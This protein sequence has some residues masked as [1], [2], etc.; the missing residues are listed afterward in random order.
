M[1]KAEKVVVG[2]Y[3]QQQQSLASDPSHSAWV[4]ANAGSGKT[5]VLARRVVRL[6]FSGCD[7]SRI[8]CLTFT[9]A[10]AGEMSNRVFAILGE[11]AVWP[12]EQ[13]I[14]EL[15]E[16]QGK[17]PTRLQVARARTLF[18]RALETPGGLK[19][20][21]VHAFCEALLHQFP[22]EANIPGN[23]SVMEDA[24]QKTLVEQARRAVI[25]DAQTQNETPL[26]TAFRR[27]LEFGTDH[28]FEK[29][30]TQI[31]ARRDELAGWLKEIGGPHKA[32]L[33][34]KRNFGF[35]G[36]ETAELLILSALKNCRLSQHELSVLH[37]AGKDKKEKSW[38]RRLSQRIGSFLE[39]DNA[40]RK[41]EALCFIFLSEKSEPRKYSA[42]ATGGL[43]DLISDFEARLEAEQT[44]LLE[45]RGRINTL[46][47]IEETE[48]LLVIAQ[49]IINRYSAAKRRR[50]LL[51][52][53][54][55]VSAA[56]NLL[57]RSSARQWVLYKLDLGIDH[58]LLDEAQDT[59]PRQW[60]IIA[61]LGAEFFA[62]QGARD[63]TRTVFAVGDEKQSI[64]SFQGARPENFSAQRRAFQKAAK[65][66][67][68]TF[69]TA[70]LNVSFR[71]TPDVL[72]AVDEV[73]ST[74]DNQKGLTSDEGYQTH[75][76]VRR[77]ALGRVDLWP[78]MYPQDS[79]EP[80]RWHET[81]D[82]G[83]VRH[84][85]ILLADRI[86][87]QIRQWLDNGERIEGSG[88]CVTPGDILVLVRARDRFVTALNRALKDRGV[89]VAGA[90]RL[91]LVD[92]IAVQDL[93]AL[94][95]V[96]LTTADDL[97]LAAL[98]KSPLFGL[99]EEQ[100][101]EL[102]YDRKSTLFDA[103]KAR[104]GEDPYSHINARLNGWMA[105]ADAI[106]VYE[107]YAH[108]L[109]AGGG[110]KAFYARLGSE[111]E[112]V[113]DSFLSLA[114]AHEKDG[115]PGLL[116]FLET[117]ESARPE[118]KREFDQTTGE[119][120]VMTVHAAKGLE[121]PIVFVVD[122][123]DAAF[124]A[125]HAPALYRWN[126]S[127]NPSNSDHGYLWVPSSAHHAPATLSARARVEELA[128]EE[129]R[130]LLYVAMTR[131]KDRLVICGYTGKQPDQETG[132]FKLPK[133]N[134][135][136]MVSD[137][138]K[139]EASENLDDSGNVTDW[140]WRAAP[141]RVPAEKVEDDDEAA[142][143]AHPL[144]DWLDR[145]LSNERAL[146]RPLTPSGAQALIDENQLQERR[147]PSLLDNNEGNENGGT[148]LRKRG[149]V[150]HALL[151]LLPGLAGADRWQWA[152]DYVAKSIPN[153]PAADRQSLLDAI[154]CLIED[155]A[156]AGFFDP[157][158][159]KAEVPV[160]GQLELASGPRSVSG[161]I[162][163]ICLQGKTVTLLDYKTTLDPPDR[164]DHVPQD[165]VAQ[166]ALYQ[167][168]VGR[169]YPGSTVKTVLVWTHHS[170]GPNLME[171]PQSLLDDAY[172]K[173]AD[174]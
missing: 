25:V 149:I 79:P 80:E 110:R 30:V 6:L 156:L 57:R 65:A 60:Q 67:Q 44:R 105:R 146:P 32:T 98:L 19:I 46:R 140:H 47:L 172:K 131:A 69:Q 68:K 70:R 38:D 3:T 91:S 121:A 62:G 34:A 115:L 171:L 122:K 78:L 155:D 73:F 116:S 41:F 52:F 107:F 125:Q 135:H 48:P 89:P 111:A 108:V 58:I 56:A 166:M 45:A 109:G 86:A 123:C 92:H 31:I 87:T 5:F 84:Q 134:W 138:L 85:A 102:A 15:H 145:P 118:I 136:S 33:R 127:E 164:A 36:N 28:A 103:L 130:R 83:A 101:F 54:D 119:V 133:P 37:D 165:Y 163:R 51:D 158:T 50:G 170:A 71:S 94:G 39:A 29:A 137:C 167:K 142:S 169:L 76:A 153:L 128:Q 42:F 152:A 168:L 97:S 139:E 7:P 157:A 13:L 104:S 124:R 114:L 100:L 144:P 18:A 11:W 21:T 143:I 53:D 159:S 162:D 24:V 75:E 9:N 72:G 14:K 64:Y 88:K 27:V 174:L 22:L 55:L 16:M 126:S 160:M 61:S 49:A 81:M 141:A 63:A 154:R 59:S 2:D 90:D 173:I 74:A 26:A 23:F 161:V 132:E 151:Q 96:M 20:Q 43:K 17:P 40:V 95:K 150:I 66:S 129:Y 112:D 8:L 117:L 10:A 120:R 99:S 106:P 35:A 148:H 82:P 147:I 4:S 77:N 12:E 93:I 1:S 113:L